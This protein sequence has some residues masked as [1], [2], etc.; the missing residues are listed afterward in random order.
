[1][2]SDGGGI[3]DAVVDFV[4]DASLET[5]EDVGIVA[6]YEIEISTNAYASLFFETLK[7]KKNRLDWPM[8]MQVNM[9]SNAALKLMRA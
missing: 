2:R 1:M 5:V 4:C 9:I 7:F 3:R 8:T 6:T